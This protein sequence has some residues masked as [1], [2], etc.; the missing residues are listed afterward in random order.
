MTR[1]KILS[2]LYYD[3]TFCGF[4]KK[5]RPVNLQE[6]LKAEVLLIMS[7]VSEDKLL[8]L[9]ERG[10][11][12]GFA[13]G[14]TIRQI[15]SNTSAFYKKYRTEIP[16]LKAELEYCDNAQLTLAK[17]AIGELDNLTWYERGLIDLYCDLGNYRAVETET[18]IPHISVYLTVKNACEKIRKQIG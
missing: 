16:G 18:G 3:K 1:S 14:I 8:G 10:K 6:D 9:Y 5:M 13:I 17:A 15:K 12:V 2:D 7:E 11:I 4:I